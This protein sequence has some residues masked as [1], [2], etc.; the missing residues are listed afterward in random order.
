MI[1]GLIS[2]PKHL[3]AERLGGKGKSKG[4]ITGEMFFAS[5]MD[6]RLARPRL[7]GLGEG[8]PANASL[9]NRESMA[10]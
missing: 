4:T 6:V 10:L 1:L 7:P 9:R 5:P 8:P 3:T 2:C